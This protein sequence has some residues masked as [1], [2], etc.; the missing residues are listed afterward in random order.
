MSSTVDRGETPKAE[1]ALLGRIWRQY[2]RVRWKGVSVSIFFAVLAAAAS[3]AILFQLSYVVDT[4]LSK[5]GVNYTWFTVPAFVGAI[6]VVRGLALIGQSTVINRVG[7]GVVGDIQRQLVG[8]FMRGDLARLRAT[9]TGGFVSQIL[10][11]ATLVREAFTTGVVNYVQNVL[12][13]AGVLAAMLWAD[14]PLTVIVL[15]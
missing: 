5:H 13:L 14:W 12:V 4:L 3:S 8:N 11:D 6:G 7:H 1:R 9:H 15:V 10:F 2:L